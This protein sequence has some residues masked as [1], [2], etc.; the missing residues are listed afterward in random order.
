VV[1][2]SRSALDDPVEVGLGAIGL[3]IVVGLLLT[4]RK[5]G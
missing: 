3:F 5:D 4:R 2:L 1:G